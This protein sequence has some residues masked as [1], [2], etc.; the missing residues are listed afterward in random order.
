MDHTN[1]IFSAGASSVTFA[2]SSFYQVQGYRSGFDGADNFFT[3]YLYRYFS[4]LD[5]GRNEVNNT[6][7][8]S[9]RRVAD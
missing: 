4:F 8:V 9:Q 3:S 7:I 2:Y 1:G 5:F 6:F